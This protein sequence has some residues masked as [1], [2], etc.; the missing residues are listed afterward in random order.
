M[1]LGLQVFH[2]F[3]LIGVGFLAIRLLRRQK[4]LKDRQLQ[5]IVKGVHVL[6]PVELK[7]EICSYEQFL[8]G[9]GN[10]NLK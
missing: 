3:G 2:R 1:N 5:N 6:A 7:F 10:T 9:F 4:S 8:K